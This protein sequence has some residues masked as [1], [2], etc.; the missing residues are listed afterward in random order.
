MD[1]FV[2]IAVLFAAVLHAAWNA[3]VK[4][5][6]DRFLSMSTVNLVSSLLALPLILV[7]PLPPVE[8]WGWLLASILIHQAYYVA[9]ILAYRH[10]DLSQAYPLA[11]GSAPLLVAL[12]AWLLAGESLTPLALGGIAITALGILSLM[13]GLRIREREGRHALFFALATGVAISAYT[14]ADGMGGRAGPAPWSY[15]AWLFFIEGLPFPLLV[16]VLR[17]RAVIV[18]FLRHGARDAALGGVLS[19]AAYCIVIWALTR[20]PMSSVSALRETSVVIAAMIGAV[21][22]GERFGR[23]RIAAALV[24]A[25]GVVV[26]QLGGRS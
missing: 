5:S 12:G 26:L 7:L 1:P 16:P 6:T 11:R 3:L 8:A 22:L 24:V 25:A 19:A 13:R 4:S 2:A 23:R 15:I 21:F 9:L 10:G 17:R 14:V 18:A 20:A